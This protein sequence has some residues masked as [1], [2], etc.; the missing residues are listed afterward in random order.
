MIKK[1]YYAIANLLY[2][3]QVASL[4][5]KCRLRMNGRVI[6]G[7][8]VHLADNVEIEKNWIIAVYPEFGGSD[9]PVKIN[10]STKGV[11]IEEGASFN[12]NLTIYCAD[13]VRIGKNV[14]FGSGVLV[15]DNDHGMDAGLEIPFR[16]QKLETS[17]VEIGDNCWI[18]E[19][20]KILRGTKIGRNSIVAAGAI[21]K[22]EYPEYSLIAGIPAKVIKTWN[23]ESKKWERVLRE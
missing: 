14:L 18:A 21:V 11:W 17:S 22:G 9:N 15:S 12:R 6:G 3:Y 20:A 16:F 4:G 13:S 5:K 2:R 1:I 7:A 19:D 10:S 8:Y 23:F